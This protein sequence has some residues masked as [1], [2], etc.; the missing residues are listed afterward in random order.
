[1]VNLLQRESQELWS[2]TIPI[3]GGIESISLKLVVFVSN[4]VVFNE[5]VFP[6]EH[7]LA[8]N[9]SHD[10]ATNTISGIPI[11]PKTGSNTTAPRSM[12]NQ[13]TGLSE[14]EDIPINSLNTSDISSSDTSSNTTASSTHSGS[15]HTCSSR[16]SPSSPTLSL[17]IDS[18][19]PNSESTLNSL[20][21]LTSSSSSEPLF[22]SA[23][24]ISESS[25]HNSD[26]N[27]I[28]SLDSNISI[29]DLQNDEISNQTSNDKNFVDVL[30]NIPND[31]ISTSR[32][33][34]DIDLYETDNCEDSHSLLTDW[35]LK[36]QQALVQLYNE[37]NHINS[38]F[39]NYIRDLA[40][41]MDITFQVQNQKI[42]QIINDK[43]SSQRLNHDVIQAQ[44]DVSPLLKHKLDTV[45]MIDATK[46]DAAQSSKRQRVSNTMDNSEHLVTQL[47]SLDHESFDSLQIPPGLLDNSDEISMAVREIHR[48]YKDLAKSAVIP[49]EWS[50][51]PTPQLTLPHSMPQTFPLTHQ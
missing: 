41:Q 43:S 26:P 10:P 31:N 12:N 40:S 35:M 20:H 32:D 48:R 15:D 16:N 9:I 18:S 50:T 17:S 2:V 39:H 51:G 38:S 7:T 6:L 33:E 5:N 8:V 30:S 3:I 36:M 45:A 14:S 4:Q 37:S 11:Y 34:M 28:P 13:N 47:S 19:S 27:Y 22:P 29:Q 42:S 21:D 49:S 24:D 25:S 23:S 1:M 46:P 44:N